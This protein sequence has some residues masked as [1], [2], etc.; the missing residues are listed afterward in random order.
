MKLSAP[1]QPVFLIAVALAVLSL[2]GFLGVLA[3]LGTYAY[4]L[5][6][7][8]FAVLATACVLKGM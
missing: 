5:M 7:A 8:A 1:T 6:A 2:V 3:P 4:W